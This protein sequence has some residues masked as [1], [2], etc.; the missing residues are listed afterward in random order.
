MTKV[1]PEQI[2]AAFHLALKAGDVKAVDGFLR[3]LA[4]VDPRRA[5]ELLDQLR[6]ALAL[7]VAGER[8]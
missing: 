2:E 7:R 8:P 5:Q 1:T 3:M 4:V 6:L